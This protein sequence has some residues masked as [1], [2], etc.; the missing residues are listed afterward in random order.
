MCGT[1]GCFPNS[2]EQAVGRE[3]GQKRLF[4]TDHLGKR[5]IQISWLEC[6]GCEMRRHPKE[7][8]GLSFQEGG[9]GGSRTGYPEG[10]P[11][12]EAGNRALERKKS[13]GPEVGG[14]PEIGLCLFLKK[15]IRSVSKSNSAINEPVMTQLIISRIIGA[16]ERSFLQLNK[17]GNLLTWT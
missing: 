4:S 1:K 15:K 10:L 12:W 17:P 2:P 11:F 3:A 8:P 13:P 9:G 14:E 7:C 6:K 5:Q 16:N